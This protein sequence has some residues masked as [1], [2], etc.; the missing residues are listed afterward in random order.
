MQLKFLFNLI[1]LC[2]YNEINLK[3]PEKVHFSI[4][5]VDNLPKRAGFL[6]SPV[7][8]ITLKC[9]ASLKLDFLPAPLVLGMFRFSEAGYV[10][11]LSGLT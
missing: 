1:C 9:C 6:S 2:N 10:A 3:N 4:D 11:F 7:G 5:L 8:C